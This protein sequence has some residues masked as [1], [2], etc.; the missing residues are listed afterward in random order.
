MP[1]LSPVSLKFL[2]IYLIRDWGSIEIV[3]DEIWDSIKVLYEIY[4][5]S[6]TSWSGNE[7]SEVVLQANTFVV[8]HKHRVTKNKALKKYLR[9][10]VNVFS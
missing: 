1:K 8:L 10:F 3:L 6:T 4:S 5:T 9:V 2:I 7:S